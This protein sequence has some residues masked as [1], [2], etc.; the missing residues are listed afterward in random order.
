M[1]D[2]SKGGSDEEST[3][4]LASGSSAGPG[5]DPNPNPDHPITEWPD[6]RAHSAEWW[7]EYHV[8]PKLGDENRAHIFARPYAMP[9]EEVS[10][11]VARYR[12]MTAP[13]G[14]NDVPVGMQPH[15]RRRRRDDTVEQTLSR[16][17]SDGGFVE[18]LYKYC[19]GKE[20]VSLALGNELAAIINRIRRS[21][22]EQ[23][24]LKDKE[25]AALRNDKEKEK[26]ES[27]K[28][29]DDDGSFLEL[30]PDELR[31]AYARAECPLLRDEHGDGEVD[32]SVLSEMLRQM[33]LLKL[34]LA[35]DMAA[36]ETVVRRLLGFETPPPTAEEEAAIAFGTLSI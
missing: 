5:P 10:D 34:D 31:S 20:R 1:S 3:S 7:S 16:M 29:D 28:N 21:R 12:A 24:A 26:E 6:R 27:K 33:N 11:I 32:V 2:A 35:A 8:A 13:R 25:I 14:K 22:A 19:Q 9:A 36:R 18:G 15:L 17:L 4:S 30:E 23:I